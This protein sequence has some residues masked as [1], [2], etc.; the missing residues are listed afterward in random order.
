MK[1]SNIEDILAEIPADRQAMAADIIEELKF[2]KIMMARLK[3]VIDERGV[4]ELC[5]K[6]KGRTIVLRESPA[7]R[8]YTTALGKYSLLYRQLENLLPKSVSNNSNELLDFI[9]AQNEA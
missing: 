3:K 6:G 9:Q 1:K 5:P 7:V 4:A 8:G 2:T